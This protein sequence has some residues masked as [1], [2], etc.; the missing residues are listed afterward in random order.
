MDNNIRALRYLVAL[1]RHELGKKPCD[2]ASHAIDDL[3]A[4]IERLQTIVNAAWLARTE[5]PDYTPAPDLALRAHY[6]H[7]LYKLLDDWK[8]AEAGKEEER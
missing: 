4:D 2:A 8:A 1:A 6:R 3:Q 7:Q 5:Q